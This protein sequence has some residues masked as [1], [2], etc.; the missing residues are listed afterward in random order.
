MKGGRVATAAMDDNLGIAANDPDMGSSLLKR[1]V[2]QLELEVASLK[3]KLRSAQDVI[4]QLEKVWAE[5]G[6][7]ARRDTSRK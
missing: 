6:F 1:Q 7:R 5:Q 3:I 4:L 2:E